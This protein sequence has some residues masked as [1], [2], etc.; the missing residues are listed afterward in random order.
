VSIE[1][2][3]T[4]LYHAEVSGNEKLV[5]LGIA[6]HEGDGGAFPAVDTLARYANIDRRSTQRLLRNLEAK[7]LLRSDRRTGNSTLYRVLVSC[8]E[9]CD[10]STNHRLV[11]NGENGRVAFAGG[12]TTTT[13]DTGT[14]GDSTTTPGGD[15]GTTGGATLQPPEPSYN[16]QENLIAFKQFWEGYPRK[17]NSRKAQLEF[18]KL[19]E[20]EQTEAIVK[21]TE[22]AESVEAEDAKYVPYPENWLKNKRF[23]DTYTPSSVI[24]YK[25]KSEQERAQRIQEAQQPKPEP[26]REA[27]P[28]C[29]QDNSISILKCGHEDCRK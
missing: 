27:P 14:T 4:V 12:D 29:L 23:L 18:F 21:A 13:G 19:D 8:P 3:T 26:V 1:K 5:L 9:N 2:M 25:K 28:K 20:H 22:F 17:I 10:R 16:R 7:G 15:T 24:A 11:R 6:N